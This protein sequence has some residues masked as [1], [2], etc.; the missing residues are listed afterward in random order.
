VLIRVVLIEQHT[1]D[2]SDNVCVCLAENNIQ[3]SSSSNSRLI[4]YFDK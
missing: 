4:L 3:P 1:S 2:A